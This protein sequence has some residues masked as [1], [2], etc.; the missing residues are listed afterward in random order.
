[1][2]DGMGALEDAAMIMPIDAENR[3]KVLKPGEAI[4]SFARDPHRQ[5][6]FQV[7]ERSAVIKYFGETRVEMR[8]GLFPIG[9]V[10][11]TAVVFRVGRHVKQ[12]YVTWWNYHQTGNAEIFQAMTA[13]EFLSFHFYGDNLR[14]DRTFVVM[15]PLREFFKTAIDTIRK[16]P[17]WS[18]D[19]F[20]SARLTVCSRFPTP[21]SMWETA[22]RNEGGQ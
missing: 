18:E 5:V 11:V 7:R 17:V 22:Q 19:E 6:V 9:T 8:A 12:E 2:F 15:N 4:Y 21:D 3:I 20:L 14:R 16:L 13:Q 10:G 1:M